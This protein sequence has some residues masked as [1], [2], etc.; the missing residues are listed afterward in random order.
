[1]KFFLFA[2]M[3]LFAS[4]LAADKRAI[5]SEDSAGTLFASDSCKAALDNFLTGLFGGNRRQLRGSVEERKL[6]SCPAWCFWDGMEQMCILFYGGRGICPHVRKLEGGVFAAS[7]TEDTTEST[8][9][10]AEIAALSDKC[11]S[12]AGPALDIAL[13]QKAKQALKPL[14]CDASQLHFR[15]QL[16][17]CID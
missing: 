2:F 13:R 14:G 9:S 8:L 10:E 3:A 15:T 4:S 11:W 7:R 16:Y 17:T 5:V 6:P 1:M 12:D